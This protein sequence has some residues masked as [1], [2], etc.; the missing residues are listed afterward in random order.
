LF[1]CYICG[2]DF[3]VQAGHIEYECRVITLC[4][5]CALKSLTN[6]I[7]KCA[8]G[9]YDFLAKHPYRLRILASRLELPLSTQE[10]MADGLA[11]VESTVCPACKT[12]EPTDL[13]PDEAP[14]T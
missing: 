3:Y 9:K 14:E 8:C 12:A 11:L 6:L 5:L 1:N 13:K 10:L 4:R 2:S 7:F